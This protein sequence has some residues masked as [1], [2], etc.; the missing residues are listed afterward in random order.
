MDR[1]VDREFRERMDGLRRRLEAKW[2][3]LRE[4]HLELQQAFHTATR[5]TENARKETPIPTENEKR[6]PER[7]GQQETDRER[8][9]E[10]DTD[11][12]EEAA[13]PQ[14]PDR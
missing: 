1:E 2:A 13:R 14:S 8:A 7:V 10:R 3:E 11:K 12:G 5:Q 6:K 4:R 9:A